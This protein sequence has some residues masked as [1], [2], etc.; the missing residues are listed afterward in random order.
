MI[1][2]NSSTESTEWTHQYKTR[3][4][5]EIEDKIFKLQEK[6]STSQR[7]KNITN[8]ENFSCDPRK[9][10]CL[11]NLEED[12]CEELNLAQLYPEVLTEME[13][14]LAVLKKSVQK[15]LNQPGD[16]KS[17]PD[18]YNG[19]WTHWQETDDD[20]EELPFSFYFIHLYI[21]PDVWSI[22]ILNNIVLKILTVPIVFAFRS[23]LQP[24][25]WSFIKTLGLIVF[26]VTSLFISHYLHF[27]LKK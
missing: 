9:S 1:L 19:T 7:S 14:R 20:E 11:F 25:V 21:D 3:I 4:T 5:H 24:F 10:A 16:P 6:Y 8:F 26:L 13:E 22:S 27:A 12:P 18:L 23:V 17:D 2:T 15:P